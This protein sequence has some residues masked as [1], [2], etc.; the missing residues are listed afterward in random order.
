L[1]LLFAAEMKR[2]VASRQ[3]ASGQVFGRSDI[4]SQVVSK[5]HIGQFGLGHSLHISTKRAQVNEIN[6]CYSP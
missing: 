3:T 6:G 5:G 1:T 2:P 4:I